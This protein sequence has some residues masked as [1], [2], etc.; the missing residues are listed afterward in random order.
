MRLRVLL[1]RV[2]ALADPPEQEVGVGAEAGGAVGE[3]DHARL[4]LLLEHLEELAAR[5]D[6]LVV[7][8]PAEGGVEL[9]EREVDELPLDGRGRAG[10]A[11]AK[12]LS[13]VA[14]GRRRVRSW[15]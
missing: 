6:L 3:A 8:E 11:R 13:R 5:L 4:G 1:E 14:G 10:G 9:V 7:V 15:V 2:G 12:G